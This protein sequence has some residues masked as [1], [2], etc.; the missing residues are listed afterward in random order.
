MA[1]KKRRRCS[2]HCLV[3]REMKRARVVKARPERERERAFLGNSCGV[4]LLP[5]AA[6]AP[7]PHSESAHRN[8]GP[9]H[10]GGTTFS[11]STLRQ[12]ARWHRRHATTAPEPRSCRRAGS[13]CRVLQARLRT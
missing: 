12:N 6:Q 4:R 11:L 3:E 5:L 9:R 1:L 8:G 7:Q 2:C 10:N 13:V